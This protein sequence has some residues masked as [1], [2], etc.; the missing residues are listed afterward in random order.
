MLVSGQGIACCQIEPVPFL[1]GEINV[2]A[3]GNGLYALGVHAADNGLYVCGMTQ[4]PGNGDGGIDNAVL[5]G[6]LGY[7]LI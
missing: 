3:G 6:D 7:Y 5:F 1:A 4:Y 2:S